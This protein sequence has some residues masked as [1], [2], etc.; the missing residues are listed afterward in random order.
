MIDNIKKQFFCADKSQMLTWY[1][2]IRR[3]CILKSFDANF[4]I[5]ENIG[6]G[7]Y[8]KVFKVQSRGCGRIYAAKIIK[9]SRL[10][11]SNNGLVVLL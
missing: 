3:H 6:E 4:I 2:K 5:I 7:S 8:A 10:T 1:N 11:A 9:K